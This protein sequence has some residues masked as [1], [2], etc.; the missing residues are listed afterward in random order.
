M[1]PDKL[2]KWILAKLAIGWSGKLVL[3]VKRGTVTRFQVNRDIETDLEVELDT[4][5]FSK[6]LNIGHTK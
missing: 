2:F 4:N 5:L 1:N 3:I 6:Q